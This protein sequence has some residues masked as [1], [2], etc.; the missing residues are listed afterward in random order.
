MQTTVTVN[1]GQQVRYQDHGGDGP[2][3]V[4]LHSFLMDLEMFAPQVAA[5]LG[6]DYRLIALNERGH[7]GTP[8]EQPFTYW[9]I[10]RDALALMDHLG[11]EKAGV[12]GTS[13][14][15]FIALRMALLAPERILAVAALGTSADAEDPQV[16]DSYRQLA[17][18]W[19]ANGPVDPLLDTV[20]SICLGDMDASDWKAR[21]RTVTGERFDRILNVLVDRDSLLDRL[22]E[23]QC[24]ALVMHGAE[25][26]AYPVARAEEMADGLPNA[27]DLVVVPG[28]AHFLSLTDPDAVNP[29]LKAFFDKHMR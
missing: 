24:P 12:V 18:G 7:E 6:E 10:A 19:V 11:V 9:D 14:G 8:A 28:G 13:Q 5:G 26:G 16:A 22:G 4:M 17:A 20:A 27:E 23:I 3:L 29:R 25:D 15:G 1:D 2:A 21:W